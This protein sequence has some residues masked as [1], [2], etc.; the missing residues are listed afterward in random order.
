[1][2]QLIASD[3][4]KHGSAF[5]M[6]TGTN[7]FEYMLD[8]MVENEQIDEDQKDEY[9]ITLDGYRIRY[10][11]VGMKQALDTSDDTECICLLYESAGGALCAGLQYNGSSI[12]AY[13]EWFRAGLFTV[14]A[15]S[16]TQLESEEDQ[17]SLWFPTG[18]DGTSTYVADG[19]DDSYWS[20]FKF[21]PLESLDGYEKDWRF[22]PR[23][24][25]VV[26]FIYQYDAATDVAYYKEG[27]P[28]A[29]ILGASSLVSGA[30]GTLVTLA[31][32]LFTI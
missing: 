10:M 20:V 31:A 21:Q 15:S 23:D 1:M 22:T 32:I 29:T 18:V 6:L 9:L 30:L 25:N 16:L 7:D 14:S 12:V 4:D 24:T 17:S 26:P 28:L 27:T 19:T 11:M 5:M 3:D 2:T 8:L 13:A